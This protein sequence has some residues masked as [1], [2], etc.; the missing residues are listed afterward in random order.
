M[1]VKEIQ[2]SD[3]MLL[4]LKGA[5]HDQREESF[6]QGGEGVLHYQG[7]LCVPDVGEL[8]QKILVEAHNSIHSIH[9]G[10]T[11]M[12]HDLREVNWWNGIKRHI[13]DFVSR[14]PNCHKVN[15]E[16]HKPCGMT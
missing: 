9:Q 15:V 4:E 2:D 7:R 12:Y 11:K 16:H 8:R 13:T 5:V 14:F 10:F 6:S 3:P 1:E